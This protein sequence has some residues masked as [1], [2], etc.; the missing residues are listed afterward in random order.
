[1]IP[2]S[3]QLNKTNVEMALPVTN[4]MLLNT[5]EGRPSVKFTTSVALQP[6]GT[7]HAS[8]S[9][10]KDMDVPFHMGYGGLIC[11]KALQNDRP[12]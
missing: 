2:H 9:Q 5:Y 11:S 6:F 4:A 1:M 3:N 10:M 8:I 12:K 7:Y